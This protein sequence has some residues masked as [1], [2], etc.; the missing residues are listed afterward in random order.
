[1]SEQGLFQKYKIEKTDGSPVD[2]DAKYLVL[3]LD[4]DDAAIAAAL[5]YI[6]HVWEFVAEE[7]PDQVPPFVSDL[8][9]LLMELDHEAGLQCPACDGRE[10][11]FVYASEEDDGTDNGS[12]VPCPLCQEIVEQE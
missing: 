9:K 3:R 5:A 4:T 10:E 7:L 12:Y 1:M 2:P 8:M 11:V 6:A